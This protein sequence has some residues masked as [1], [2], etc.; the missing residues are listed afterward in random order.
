MDAMKKEELNNYFI[1]LKDILVEYDLVNKPGQIFNVDE[2]GMSLEH[3]SPKIL[4]RKGQKKV[5]YCTSGNK[6]QITV[7]G[8]INA[9]GQVLPPFIMLKI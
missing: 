5:Q 3:W 4:A 7:V 1:T 6:S 9:I 2:S 8:C